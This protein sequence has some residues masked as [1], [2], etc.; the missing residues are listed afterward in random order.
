MQSNPNRLVLKAEKS[1]R[2]YRREDNKKR[3]S[4]RAYRQKGVRR[5]SSL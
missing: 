3:K 1:D 5:V 2:S 4:L